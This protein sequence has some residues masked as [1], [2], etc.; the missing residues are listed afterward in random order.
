[1]GLPGV[2]RDRSAAR[3]DHEEVPRTAVTNDA[4]SMLYFDMTGELVPA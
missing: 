1:V 4:T 2:L 3:G